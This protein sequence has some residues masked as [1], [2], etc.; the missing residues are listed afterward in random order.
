[1]KLKIG[2]RVKYK[3]E[4]FKYSSD[5]DIELGINAYTILSVNEE[6]DGFINE[7]HNWLVIEGTVEPLNQAVHCKTKEE[8]KAVLEYI[9]SLG[10]GAEWYCGAIPTAFICLWNE[11]KEETCLNISDLNPLYCAN[12]K[13]YQKENYSIITAQEYLRDWKD[14]P[15]ERFGMIRVEDFKHSLSEKVYKNGLIGS[16]NNNEAPELHK[17]SGNIMQ[18]LTAKIIRTFSKDEKELYKAGYVNESN[19]PTETLREMMLDDMFEAYYK[20]NKKVYVELAKEVNKE[21]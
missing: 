12:K 2:Q 21:K 9:E 14:N 5:K 15:L 17:K 16:I 20:E 13:Y 3:E 19:E 10:I 1:M 6:G 4:Y 11:K 7:D 8:F 18:K